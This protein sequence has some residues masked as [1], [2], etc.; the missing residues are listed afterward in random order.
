MR[1]NLVSACLA[2]LVVAPVHAQSVEQLRDEYG[3][4]VR[5]AD[6]PD[7]TSQDLVM[8][9]QA[10]RFFRKFDEARGYLAVLHG[11]AA[12]AN[13]ARCA[14]CHVR[15]RCVSCHHQDEDAQTAACEHPTRGMERIPVA[16]DRSVVG[17]HL[18]AHAQH[19]NTNPN[20]MVRLEGHADE[21]GTREYN[22]ALGER[23]GNAVAK[24]LRLNGVSAS[25]MEVISYGE[26]KPVAYGHDEQ[27]WAANRRV[28][29]VYTSGQ[30]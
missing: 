3:I 7:A 15:E 17:E 1:L 8:A 23:R 26:E 20:A 27:S 5:A 21:R 9:A 28:E 24:Y 13:G 12:L 11:A 19:L 30:P 25:Q 10:A 29:L 22:V 4:R 2:L 18:R 6:S 16:G 14:T